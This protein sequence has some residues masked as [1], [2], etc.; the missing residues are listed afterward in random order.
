MEI[1]KIK[2]QLIKFDGTGAPYVKWGKCKVGLDQ[3][4]C[5]PVLFIDPKREYWHGM[6]CTRDLVIHLSDCC[7][8]AILGRISE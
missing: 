8:S 6:D 7:E 4:Y 2:E 3:F 1:R 5:A